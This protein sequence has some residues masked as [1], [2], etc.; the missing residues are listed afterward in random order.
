MTR[1]NAVATG[2]TDMLGSSVSQIKMFAYSGR[3]SSPFRGG[4]ESG[5]RGVFISGKKRRARARNRRDGTVD[6]G[7]M[8]DKQKTATERIIGTFAVMLV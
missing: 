8:N 4:N 7:I 2:R 3:C 6:Y 1:D 5:T